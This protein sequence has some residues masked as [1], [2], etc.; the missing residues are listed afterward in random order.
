MLLYAA[1]F[2]FVFHISKNSRK[3]HNYTPR[4]ALRHRR[5]QLCQHPR[6]TPFL[7]IRPKATF[8]EEQQQPQQWHTN[9]KK[10]GSACSVCA[11]GTCLTE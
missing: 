8:L 4:R 7:P 1:G 5:L 11:V 9:K 6:K 10:L 3:L 2:V